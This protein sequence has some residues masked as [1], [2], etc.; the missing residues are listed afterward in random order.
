M[1]VAVA[2]D[3]GLD[4]DDFPDH[5]F[6]GELATRNR[7]CKVF[8]ND[9]GPSGGGVG[10]GAV[11]DA[12]PDRIGALCRKDACLAWG[13]WFQGVTLADQRLEVLQSTAC[14][15]VNSVKLGRFA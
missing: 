1:F 12:W 15:Q 3:R 14:R 7:W 5:A 11:A 4:L 8:D 6:D 13:E 2:I 10:F 9:P